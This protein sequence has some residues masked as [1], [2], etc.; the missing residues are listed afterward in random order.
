MISPT[1][2]QVK[3]IQE[4]TRLDKKDVFQK[5]LKLMEEAGELAQAVLSNQKA[6][7]CEYKGL[8]KIDV[9]REVADTIICAMAVGFMNDLTADQLNTFIWEKLDSWEKKINESKI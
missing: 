2:F 5:C 8:D 4:L 3:K 9:G 6:P 1:D 7:T